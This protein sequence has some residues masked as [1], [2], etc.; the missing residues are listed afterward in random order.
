MFYPILEDDNCSIG[1]IE[2]L[3]LSITWG[4]QVFAAYNSNWEYVIFI[5][6]CKIAETYVS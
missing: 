6:F 1:A 5:F 2:V 3:V 4:V